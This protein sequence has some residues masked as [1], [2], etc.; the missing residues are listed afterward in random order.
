MSKKEGFDEGDIIGCEIF[1]PKGQYLFYGFK[2]KLLEILEKEVAKTL[3]DTLKEA[4]L[5]KFKSFYYFESRTNKKA[6]DNL[7]ERKGSWIQFYKNGVPLGK[8][9]ENI[10]DG[11][12]FPGISLF[13]TA[14]VK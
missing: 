13:K 4:T 5:V 11:V 3:P 7:T 8:A 9:F 1:I 14:K 2:R 10:N 6:K 12:Y